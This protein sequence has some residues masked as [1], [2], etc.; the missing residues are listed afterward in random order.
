M[1]SRGIFLHKRKRWTFHFSKHIVSLFFFFF[2]PLYNHWVSPPKND[3]ILFFGPLPYAGKQPAPKALPYWL[4]KIGGAK[5][6]SSAC[7][8]QLQFFKIYF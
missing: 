6:K 7:H 3:F 1:L 4:K 2:S 8:L 5:K